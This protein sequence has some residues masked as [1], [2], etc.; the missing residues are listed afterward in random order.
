MKLLFIKAAVGFIHLQL[1]LLPLALPA[2]FDSLPNF[3]YYDKR[4]INVFDLQE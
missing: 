3:R 1:V 2:Q 4:G